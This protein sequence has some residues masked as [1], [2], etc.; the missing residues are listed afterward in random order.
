VN[1]RKKDRGSPLA[2]ALDPDRAA[3]IESI[4]PPSADELLVVVGPTATGKTELAIDLAERIGGEIVNADSIQIYREFETGTGKPSAEELARAPHHLVSAIDPL[5][6]MDARIYCDL[7]DAAIRSIR[8]RGKVPI[9]CGGTFLWVKALVFGLAA[10][11]PS[12]ATIR[13]QHR[14]IAESE[15]RSALHARL[16]A[17]DPKTAARLAPNDFIRV[18]R[19]LEVFELSGKPMSAWHEEHAFRV[20]RHRARF[21]GVAR[22]AEEIDHRI[23]VRTHEWL[24]AGWV[25][26]VRDLMRRGYGESRA[27]GSV[28]FRQIAESLLGA[29]AEGDLADAIVRATRIFARRQRTWLREQPVAWVRR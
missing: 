21:V 16:T 22:S 7:A 10:A 1:A 14:T 20:T 5:A 12:D 24:R 17:V 13:E 29:L 23:E 3:S 26:E 6:P 8:D 4:E 15:G 25:D 19:A 2:A 9:V 28:G 11:P 27:M 18:S